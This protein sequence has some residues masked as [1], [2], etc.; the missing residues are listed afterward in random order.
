MSI[1]TFQEQMMRIKEILNGDCIPTMN[2]YL[3]WDYIRITSNIGKD[4]LAFCRT[5]MDERIE[6]IRL[7]ALENADIDIVQALM[8][9]LAITRLP[10]VNIVEIKKSLQ[11]IPTDVHVF[12]LEIYPA[13]RLV[14]FYRAF[15][16]R[17]HQEAY[18]L[19]LEI[20]P[21]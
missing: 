2:V 5:E 8:E 7:T 16:F 15:I 13:H 12:S 19:V 4:I 11:A 1:A 14:L 6:A 9:F 17:I 21:G 10:T 3:E 18:L 20:L